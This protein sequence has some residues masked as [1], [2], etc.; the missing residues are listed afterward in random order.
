MI[1]VVF[2][3]GKT[4]SNIALLNSIAVKD[5]YQFI[6]LAQQK[7]GFGGQYLANIFRGRIK[8]ELIYSLRGASSRLFSS[9]S[10]RKRKIF[11]LLDEKLLKQ[12]LQT[13]NYQIIEKQINIFIS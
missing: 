13:K 10:M 9:Y 6:L 11:A 12:K 2:C 1:Q 8:Y 3:H 5:M 7:S 4:S